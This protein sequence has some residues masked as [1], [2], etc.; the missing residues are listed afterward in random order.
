MIWSDLEITGPGE[1]SKEARRE[2]RRSGVTLK[3]N[4][5]I[6]LASSWRPVPEEVPRGQVSLKKGAKI[7]SHGLSALL[8]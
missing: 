1:A 5:V 4:G 2:K 7:F 3:W 8:N 6:E